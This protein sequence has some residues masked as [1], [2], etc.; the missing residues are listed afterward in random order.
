MGREFIDLFDQWAP[1]YNETVSGADEEYREA[2]ANYQGI[3]SAVAERTSGN[4]LEFG[5][6]TGNLTKLLLAKTDKVYG[7]EPSQAMRKIA[8]TNFPQAIILDG[9][10]LNFPMVNDQIDSIVSTYA[11]H[12]LTDKEKSEAIEK[13]AK[14]L[15]PHG[16]IVFA[17]TI[18]ENE[19]ARISIMQEAEHQGYF[20]LLKDLQT[21][22]YTTVNILGQ[23]FEQNGFN[24][25]FSRCN[26][27]V[28]LMEATKQVKMGV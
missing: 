27:F 11:F 4:V 13:Y 9:D 17:D 3:L 25:S 21:E 12:H 28:W 18:F 1:T 10:F 6:G 24:V 20:N 14:L 22:Y 2:F 26:K 8:K 5:V 16:K 23:I 7:M 15:P 19:Q